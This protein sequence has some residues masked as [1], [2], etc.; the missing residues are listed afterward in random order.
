MR[1]NLFKSIVSVLVLSA[2]SFI[3]AHADEDIEIPNCKDASFRDCEETVGPALCQGLNIMSS[4][5][6]M[7]TKC[8]N[9]ASQKRK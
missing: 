7:Y 5:R 3:I 6:G 9:C 2:S 8:P 1:L 4:I